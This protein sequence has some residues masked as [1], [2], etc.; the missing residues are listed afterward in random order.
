MVI[1]LLFPK[2]G[3]DRLSFQRVTGVEGVLSG[4][5]LADNRAV[6]VVIDSG[7]HEQRV[8][9]IVLNRDNINWYDHW[10][11]GLRLAL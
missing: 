2:S 1:L 5:L 10:M 9:L 3:G 11:V 4:N 8:V 6:A 7:R